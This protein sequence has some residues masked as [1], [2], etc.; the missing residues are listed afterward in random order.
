MSI[1]AII[2]AAG[3]IVANAALEAQGFGPGNFSVTSYALGRPSH[4]ALHAWPDAA[5]QAAIA[6]LPGVVIDNSEGDPGQRTKAL[7]E[8][9]GAQWGSQAPAYAGTL[10]AG[11][12]YR[13]S[14]DSLWWC[15]QPYDTAVFAD[16]PSTYPALIRRARRPGV[17]EPWVQPMDALDA[18]KLLDPFTGQP[19]VCTHAGK[20]WRVSQAD[21]A[22]NNIWE[23]G[24][25]GWSEES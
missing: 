20:T 19:E 4:A 10:T 2:P 9:Q 5:L 15:I 3:L 16:H 24:A 22:G 7:I 12:L 13:Y 11:T 1:V 6:A 14:D 17:A 21:G 23:P 25:F 8:A 18:Y